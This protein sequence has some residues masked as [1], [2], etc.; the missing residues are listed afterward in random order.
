LTTA[1]VAQ[2]AAEREPAQLS[3]TSATD[4]AALALRWAPIHYQSVDTRG[5]HS[6]AGRGDYITRYDFDADTDARNNWDHAGSG[7]YPLAAAAYFSVVETRTHWFIVYL[8]FHPRDWANTFFDTEHENDS[9]GLL[10]AVARDGSPYGSL[11]AAVTV[12]HTDFFSYLPRTSDWRAGAETVDGV[13]DLA[14]YAGELHPVTAQQSRGH[15]LKARPYYDIEAGE[16]VVYYPSLT[17][18]EVPSGPNDREVRYQLVDIFAPGGMWENRD[19]PQ[20]FSSFGSFAG[21]RS[22][23]CGDGAIGCAPN[24]AHAPW[25]WDDNDD[26]CIPGALAIDPAGLAANY[27]KVPEAL[28]PLYS[29]NP[30]GNLAGRLLIAARPRF[31]RF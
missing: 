4:R 11:K 23:G 16:G 27:F 25:A 19:N 8:F 7:S 2:A 17:E 14:R 21:N 28:S 20:L 10:L 5:A 12:A 13:L 24:A 31:G 30:Y 22:D 3:A 15:G 9:E 18:G 1:L 26:R 29:F 6:L